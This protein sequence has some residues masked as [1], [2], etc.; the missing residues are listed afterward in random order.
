M[1][2]PDEHAGQGST[3]AMST[4]SGR[5]E[6]IPSPCRQRP[7]DWIAHAREPHEPHGSRAAYATLPMALT[8]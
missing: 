7:G 2:A 1:Q 8:R 4:G 3:V 6:Y 5:T